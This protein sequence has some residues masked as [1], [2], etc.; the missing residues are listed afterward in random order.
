MLYVIY[1][2]Y[3]ICYKLNSGFL[4]ISMMSSLTK[5]LDLLHALHGLQFGSRYLKSEPDEILTA[6]LT[7]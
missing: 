4:Y 2:I 3:V 6:R 7:E 1:V 5:S